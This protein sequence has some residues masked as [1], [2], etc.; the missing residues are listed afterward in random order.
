MRKNNRMKKRVIPADELKSR[1][2][3]ESCFASFT[4]SE[5]KNRAQR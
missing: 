2:E 3:R 4:K 1:D 5:E